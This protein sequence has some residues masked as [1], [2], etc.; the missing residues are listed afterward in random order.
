MGSRDDLMSWPRGSVKVRRSILKQDLRNMP[1]DHGD[2]FLMSQAEDLIDVSEVVEISPWEK[3]ETERRLSC[4]VELGLLE[5]DNERGEPVERVRRDT[6]PDFYV[7]VTLRPKAPVPVAD[8]FRQTETSVVAL[9]TADGL[10]LLDHAVIHNDRSVFS[11]ATLVDETSKK[12]QKEKEHAKEKEKAPD[13]NVFSRVTVVD[14]DAE[15]RSA[16]F[17]EA[18]TSQKKP[19]PRGRAS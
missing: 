3:G 6:Q 1:I 9:R 10:L 5:W 7:A 11:R 2:M 19:P 8:L 15:Q 18:D 16:M 14:E 4:L 12:K 13:R 17:E